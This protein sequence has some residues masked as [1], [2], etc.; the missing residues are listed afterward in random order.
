MRKFLLAALLAA[1]PSTVSA[2]RFDD[3]ATRVFS[4]KTNVNALINPASWG[5]CGLPNRTTCLAIQPRDYRTI[6]N[7]TGFEVI[8]TNGPRNEGVNPPAN[9]NVK[10]VLTSN[11]L[12][13]ARQAN[14]LAMIYYIQKPDTVDLNNVG[15]PL[16]TTDRLASDLVNS[17]RTKGLRIVNL[18]YSKTHN[19]TLNTNNYDSRYIGSSGEDAGVRVDRGIDL[20]L[21]PLG[22]GVVERLF[23]NNMI[24][25]I[26]H[27]GTASALAILDLADI[28]G[29]VV[30][31]NHVNAEAIADH[32]RNHTDEV[33]CRIAK[34]GGIIGITPLR[35][36]LVDGDERGNPVRVANDQDIINQF[37]HI[38]GLNCLGKNGRRLNMINHIAVASDSYVNGWPQQA[39]RFWVSQQVSAPSAWMRMAAVLMRSGIITEN[40]AHKVFGG[41]LMR[42]YEQALPGL[43]APKIKLPRSGARIRVSAVLFHWEAAIAQSVGRVTNYRVVVQKRSAQRTWVNHTRLNAGRRKSTGTMLPRGSYR[44]WVTATNGTQTVS[45]SRK[46]FIRE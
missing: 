19:D 13:A 10:V 18:A 45:S 14:D 46:F 23:A 24:V 35:F 15:N 40:E 41:N 42:V 6:I 5:A 17:W 1:S 37:R 31:A 20:P 33:I 29:K 44:W 21:P 2:D 28:R 32:P 34:T 11:D 39:G 9:L 25:D 8:T 27:V 4:T 43:K 7:S 36:M 12:L 22:R 16:Y 3:A 26:S 30:T 38:R